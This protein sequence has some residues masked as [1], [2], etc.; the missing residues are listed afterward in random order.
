MIFSFPIK[1]SR[2]KAIEIE[3]AIFHSLGNP[4]GHTLDYFFTYPSQLPLQTDTCIDELVE[5]FLKS[6]KT[7]KTVQVH[8]IFETTLAVSTYFFSTN[9]YR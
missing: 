5:T 4:K 6:M 3:I 8:L 1:T 2:L 9:D 7:M